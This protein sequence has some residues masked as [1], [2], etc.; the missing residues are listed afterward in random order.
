[1]YGGATSTP[2]AID[3]VLCIA[4][5]TAA[6]AGPGRL[7][8]PKFEACSVISVRLLD[9]VDN[10][11]RL[12]HQDIPGVPQHTWFFCVLAE[13]GM[14]VSMQVGRGEEEVEEDEDGSYKQKGIKVS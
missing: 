2:S 11:V 8:E 6:L 13:R 3:A 9:A 10:E 7:A 4:S 5:L 1:L 12:G 14:D